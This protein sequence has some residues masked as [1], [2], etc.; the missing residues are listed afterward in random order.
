MTCPLCGGQVDRVRAEDGGAIE[1]AVY[2]VERARV[3]RQVGP[4]SFWACSAC[5]WC[6]E[7]AV[8]EVEI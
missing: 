4:A 3:G 8:V 2:L 6:A 7:H 5:E 1:R